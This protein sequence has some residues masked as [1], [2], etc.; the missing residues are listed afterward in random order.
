MQKLFLFS[1]LLMMFFLSGFEKN[2]DTE[3]YQN[4]LFNDDLLA[5][6]KDDKW[7]FIN[8]KGEVIIDFK[9]LNVEPFFDG[10]AIV[11]DEE[12][13]YLI[14]TKGEKIT[15]NGFNII[16]RDQETGLYWIV[17]VSYPDKYHPHFKF[18]LMDK[19]GLVIIEPIF[20]V[21][22]LEMLANR[23]PFFKDGLAIVKFNGKY[24]YL[25]VHGELLPIN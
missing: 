18:G 3:D 5:I 20:E 4:A 2:F 22:S 16:L 24:V 7:G 25:N 11:L 8:D 19:T 6:K 10:V 1:F 9:Y 12:L 17:D 13:C 15:E 23:I 21:N 14:N